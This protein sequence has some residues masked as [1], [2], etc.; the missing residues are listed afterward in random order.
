MEENP[1]QCPYQASTVLLIQKD[2]CGSD[3][4]NSLL[5]KVKRAISATSR[6]SLVICSKILKIFKLLLW[7]FLNINKSR[8]KIT[9]KHHTSNT[10]L[11]HLSASVHSCYI[12]APLFLFMRH[13]KQILDIASII[14]KYFNVLKSP[15]KFLE[16]LKEDNNKKNKIWN[17]KAITGKLIRYFYYQRILILL[18]WNLRFSNISYVQQVQRSVIPQIEQFNDLSLDIPQRKTKQNTASLVN[19]RSSESFL[20]A[21][22]RE[23]SY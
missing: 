22:E 19:V 23:Y 15:P 17:I 21:K 9:K 7:K 18:I 4:K 20:W 1:T 16:Q 14:Y 3:A 10:Q 13:W 5:Q 6:D 12:Y 2:A 11:Q 8:A